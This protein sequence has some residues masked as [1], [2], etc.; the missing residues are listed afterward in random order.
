MCWVEE[1]NDSLLELCVLK[2]GL[3]F[4]CHFESAQAPKPEPLCCGSI[5]EIRMT[6]SQVFI[7]EQ[8]RN[9]SQETGDI[10]TEIEASPPF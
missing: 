6:D 9:D 8:R 7:W 10:I 1:G 5:S 3:F 2:L 4:F